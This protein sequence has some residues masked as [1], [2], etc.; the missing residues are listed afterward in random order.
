MP[1]F[2]N[3]YT[4]LS[5][6]L[7]TILLACVHVWL[8]VWL[9]QKGQVE[10]LTFLADFDS[11]AWAFRIIVA[12]GYLLVVSFIIVFNDIYCMPRKGGLDAPGFLHLLIVTYSVSA[13]WRWGGHAIRYRQN[14]Q[15]NKQKNRNKLYACSYPH[16]SKYGFGFDTSMVLLKE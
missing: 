4:D 2:T 5:I 10:R 16:F 12:L 7:N 14:R 8:P 11:V 13:I 3:S 9:R 15:G 6:Y 1:V